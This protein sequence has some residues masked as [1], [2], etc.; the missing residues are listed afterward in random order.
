[1]M[2]SHAPSSRQV[3]RHD[4]L[5]KSESGERPASDGAYRGGGRGA[6]RL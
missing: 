1:M 4:L 3:L 5:Q 2:A 6:K